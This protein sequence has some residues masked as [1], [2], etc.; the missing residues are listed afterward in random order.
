MRT[1]TL[2]HGEAVAL[3]GRE[4]GHR[5][6][7]DGDAELFEGAKVIIAIGNLTCD[8]RIVSVSSQW[9]VVSFDEDLALPLVTVC[10]ASTTRR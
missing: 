7:Y 6:P 9:L 5:F 8:G 4:R 3:D 10:C 2:E 1:V